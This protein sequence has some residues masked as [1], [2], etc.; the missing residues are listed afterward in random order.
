MERSKTQLLR[1]SQYSDVLGSVCEK[2]W[3][4]INEEHDPDV[5]AGDD[6]KAHR[7]DGPAQI[8]FAPNQRILGWW[9]DG[10]IDRTRT[11]YAQY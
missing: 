10:K 5:D 3:G 6:V 7:L 4:Y 1:V 8:F 9:L 2:C 11:L